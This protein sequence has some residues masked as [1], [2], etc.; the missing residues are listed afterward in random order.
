[1]ASLLTSPGGLLILV[2]P[3]DSPWSIAQALT[4]RG[5]RF[6]ELVRANPGKRTTAAGTFASLVPGERLRVPGTWVETLR[7]RKVPTEK[8]DAAGLTAGSPDA[9]ALPY[10]WTYTDFQ[11]VRALARLW[12]ATPDDLMVTW[13]EESG[14]QPHIVTRLG[15]QAPDGQQ[16]YT[17]AGL[18]AGLADVWDAGK[19]RRV[20]VIDESL[21]WP[22][23]TWLTVV[24]KTPI[25][26]QLQ[27]IAQIWDKLFKAYLP[28]QT[29][30]SFADRMGVSVAAVIH[31]LNFLPAYVKGLQSS[32]Q[33]ITQKP[34][35]FYT[36]N[37]GLDVNKD[38]KI[39]L[40]DLD[41]HGQIKLAEL[42]GSK[43]GALAQ[44][45]RSPGGSSDLTALWSPISSQWK[46]LTGKPIVTNVGYKDQG[47]GLFEI[48]LIAAALAAAYYYARS[49][50]WV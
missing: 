42:E 1:M 5:E 31:A 30:S 46:N 2:E 18:I 14:L 45:A 49:K 7:A 4:G 28:G 8:D 23:G 32:E 41:A 50:A 36:S 25:A 24:E 17:Y 11:I 20:Y 16:A 15:D 37:A 35:V 26:T 34:H 19:N 22:K 21:G 13:Y 27:A 9:G 40:A 44:F 6:S 39:T 47:G 38:G 29:I 12:G 10:G 43:L 48:V 3:G 33:A